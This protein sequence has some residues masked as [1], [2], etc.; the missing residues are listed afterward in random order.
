[1]IPALPT[2]DRDALIERKR[3]FAGLCLEKCENQNVFSYNRFQLF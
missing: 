1:M 3:F 2:F